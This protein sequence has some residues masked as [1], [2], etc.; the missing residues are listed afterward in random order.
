MSIPV[1]MS[2][3]PSLGERGAVYPTWHQVAYVVFI[4]GGITSRAQL[5]SPLL[6][7]QTFLVPI[8]VVSI[9][10]PW[11]SVIYF[12]MVAVGRIFLASIA[13][14]ILSTHFLS[15]SSTL[16]CGFGHETKS[17]T[18]SA[19]SHESICTFLSQTSEFLISLILPFQALDQ[20]AISV[21]TSS[22][23]SLHRK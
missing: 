3:F 9:V 14:V 13:Q 23:Y 11:L 12:I 6:E 1:K 8:L 16:S 20:L 19:H 4:W 5:S 17:F 15:A 18:C 7:D 10:A 2:G 21:F 22:Q